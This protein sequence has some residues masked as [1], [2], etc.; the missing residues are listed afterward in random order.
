ML[1]AHRPVGKYMPAMTM[2]FRVEQARD[3]DGLAPGARVR[4]ELVVRKDQSIARR[5]VKYGES[6]IAP[7]K[8]T[9]RRG[10][11]VSDFE[12]RDQLNRPVRLSDFRGKVVAIN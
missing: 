7:P 5:V 4:F 3:L 10:D 9:L 11:A 12:L 8:E 1:V 2:P 6:E